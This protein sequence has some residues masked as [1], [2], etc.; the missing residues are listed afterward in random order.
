MHGLLLETKLRWVEHL[1]RLMSNAINLVLAA[2]V[3]SKLSP[4]D[5]WMD[6]SELMA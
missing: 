5:G 1:D 3:L 6:G 2:C 4:M